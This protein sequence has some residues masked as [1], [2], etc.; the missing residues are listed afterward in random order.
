MTAK[1]HAL[2]RIKTEKWTRFGVSVREVAEQCDIHPKLIERFVRLGLF[3]PVARDEQGSE[4]V[5]DPDIVPMVRKIMRLR[6]DLGLNYAAIG[7]VLDLLSRIERLED[8]IQ[9]LTEDGYQD[10]RKFS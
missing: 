2:V 6:N 3:D 10:L 9:T 4:W 7:V 8:R 1:K 5:F